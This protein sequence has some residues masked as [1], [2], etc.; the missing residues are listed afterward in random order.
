M[1]KKYQDYKRKKKKERNQKE[2]YTSGAAVTWGI[3]WT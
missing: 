2:K 1:T 3:E